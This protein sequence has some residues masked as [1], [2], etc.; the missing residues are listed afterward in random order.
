MRAGGSQE[1]AET[2]LQ[3]T[4]PPELTIESVAIEE[5]GGIQYLRAV[6]AAADDTDLAYLHLSLTGIR[7]SDLRRVGGVVAGARESAFL[8]TGTPVRLTPNAD[9]QQRFSARLPLTTPLSAE[10]VRRNALVLVEATAADASGNQTSLGDVRN[11]GDTVEEG[12]LGFSVAPS[13]LVFTDM[14]QSARIIPTVSYEFRGPTPIPGS[15]QGVSYSSS[16][17]GVVSVGADGLVY[18]LA[19]NPGHPVTVTV[20]FPGQASVAIPVS[21]DFSRHLTRLDYAGRDQ[22]PFHLPGLNRYYPLPALEAVFDDGSRAPLVD[23]L[24]RSY[25]LDAASAGLL[26]LDEARGLAA[27]AISAETPL[28]LRVA[29]VADPVVFVDIPITSA[30]ARPT[31]ALEV[32]ARIEVGQTLTLLANAADDTPPAVRVTDP[33][34]GSIVTVGQ[35]GLEGRKEKREVRQPVHRQALGLGDAF[36]GPRGQVGRVGEARQ[37]RPYGGETGGDLCHG[38]HLSRLHLIGMIEVA[39]FAD[40][41]TGLGLACLGLRLVDFGLHPAARS[42]MI[43]CSATT[44]RHSHRIPAGVAKALATAGGRHSPTSGSAVRQL[45]RVLRGTPSAAATCRSGSPAANRASAASSCC[46]CSRRERRVTC[47]APPASTRRSIRNTRWSVQAP[48]S[49]KQ[50]GS[51]RRL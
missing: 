44:R 45:R 4:R 5:E 8:S 7:A 23:S 13:A 41:F 42:V 6:L 2:F 17:P 36:T 32:P 10:E 18:P 9:D 50:S 24:E 28:Q 27:A 20:S 40:Q 15:G 38:L 35:T 3:E 46:A 12:V 43:R 47:L 30:D 49:R 26:R 22:G 51:P 34:A 16:D 11:L 31:L 1:Y 29:L 19:E 39:Q 48:N 25:S 21:V 33:A 37:A 14:L